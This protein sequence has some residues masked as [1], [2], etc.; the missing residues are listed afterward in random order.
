MSVLGGEF[1]IA[2]W[3]DDEQIPRVAACRDSG[4]YLVA[5]QSSGDNDTYARA[6][7]NDGIPS[8]IV[9]NLITRSMQSRAHPMLPAMQLEKNSSQFG[10]KFT[11]AWKTLT[12]SRA[13]W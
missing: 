1:G 11:L 2:E 9:H 5:W 12:A 10:R 6:V 13:G 3:P 4:N 8:T 7:S